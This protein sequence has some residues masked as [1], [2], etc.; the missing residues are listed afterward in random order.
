MNHSSA[1]CL[2][3]AQWLAVESMGARSRYCNA[4]LGPTLELLPKPC[5]FPLPHASLHFFKIE[6]LTP[7]I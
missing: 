6:L 5:N 2:V 7:F 3:I 4:T 1:I